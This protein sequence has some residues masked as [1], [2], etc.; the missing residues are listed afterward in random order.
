MKVKLCTYL[1]NVKPQILFASTPFEDNYTKQYFK[2]INQFESTTSWKE[3]LG[4][5]HVSN[6][7]LLF[8]LTQCLSC[9][10]PCVYLL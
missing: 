3:P 1:T 9:A 7:Y 2:V 6:L 5:V 4:T 10:Q 8:C